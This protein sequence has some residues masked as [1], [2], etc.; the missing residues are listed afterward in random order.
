M[1]YFI[2]I[3]IAKYKH[4][5]FIMDEMGNTV[6]DSFSFA[7]DST[8][9]NTLLY[10]LKSLDPNQE[11]RIGLEATGHY[12]SNLKIFL[13]EN[14]FSF[15]EINPI[16]INRFSKA[17]TLRRTKTD[18]LD[19]ELIAHYLLSVGYIPYPTK[20]YHISNLKSLCR[21]RECL[22][23]ERSLMLVKMTN[24]LDLMFPEFKPF[25]N[26]SLKSSTALYLLE[27]YGSPSRMARMNS[28]SYRKMASNLKRTISYAR[29]VELKNLAKN[30]VGQEDPVLTY[31]LNL[32][33]DLFKELDSRI[34]NLE[35]FISKEYLA[36]DSH[37]HSIPG[38]GLISAAGIYSEIGD[39]SRF[40]SANKV[41][42]FAGL[43][44]STNQSG[45]ESHCG[46][47]VKHGS[48]YLRKYLMNCAEISLVHNSYLYDFYLKKRNEGKAHRVALSHVARKLT[49]IIY[50]LEKND[51]DFDF[52]KMR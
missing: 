27:N 11:K 9:F 45:E 24:I 17:T 34:S 15:M 28:D 37:I 31:E 40:S 26:R 13:E 41:L 8:G 38:I 22:I 10:V 44:P 39:F 14:N 21:S 36:L 25:F 33:L 32:Y 50:S 47:M 46:H 51:V 42:A 7:N 18:K 5:C 48:S 3:D 12:G 35:S 52:N 1:T 43:D 20:S 6:C 19:A 30:T 29:F 4:D 2:G 16:L 23:R 49:S